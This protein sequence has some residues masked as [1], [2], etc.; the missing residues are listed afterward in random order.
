MLID[1]ANHYLLPVGLD[2]R[3]ID[4]NKR[5]LLCCFAHPD[6]E[7]LA[8][9]GILAKYV[10][11]GVQTYLVTATRGERGWSGD[12]AANPGLARLGQIREE[13]LARAARTLGIREVHF[14][15]YC[16]GELDQADPAEVIA[17]LVAR[18]RRIR[19]QVVI[20]F[21]P[22]GYYGHP[23]HIAISQYT[24]AAITAAAD[25]AYR[26][27]L[28]PHRVMKLYYVAPS[29]ENVARYEAAMGRLAMRIDGVER[30]SVSWPDWAITTRIDAS[31]YWAQVLRAIACHRTQLPGYEALMRLPDSEQ[32]AL[33]GTQTLYRAMSLVTGGRGVERDLFAGIEQPAQHAPTGGSSELHRVLARTRR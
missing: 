15:D 24:T 25:G 7:S 8:T 12:P 11:E 32:R 2:N 22:T 13:E 20:T 3:G 31:Q 26:S 18:L 29:A 10:A 6:D 9:G 1:G 4:M 21:D 23:D 16:D 19:P 27:T 28:P 14:L 30:H 5:R 17:Q 33:W